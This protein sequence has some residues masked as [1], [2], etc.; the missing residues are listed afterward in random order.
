MQYVESYAPY[1]FIAK[2]YGTGSH[3]VEFIFYLHGTMSE[4]GRGGLCMT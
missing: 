2:L 3:T 4:I 1:D